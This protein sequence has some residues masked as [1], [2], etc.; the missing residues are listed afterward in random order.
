M[1]EGQ[2]SVEYGNSTINFSLQLS[3]RKTVAI[4]VQPNCQVI[5]TAPE[6]SALA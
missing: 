1:K 2:Y 5:V 3:D 6:E 4:A